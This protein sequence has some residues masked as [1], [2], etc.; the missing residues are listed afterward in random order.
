[1]DLL[2]AVFEP[3]PAL[4]WGLISRGIGAVFAISFVSLALQVVPVAGSTGVIPV[5]STLA[6]IRRDFPTWKRFFYF[7]TLLWIDASDFTLRLVAWL[8]A[9]A[10]LSIIVGGPHVPYAFAACFV[11]YLSLDRPMY[12]V[13]PWDSMLFEAGFWGMLLPATLAL[14]ALEASAPPLP[15]VAWVYRLLAFRVIFGF[16]KVKFAGATAHDSG[17]LK[18]FM[19]AQPLPT[20]VGWLAQKM[21]VG[22]FKLALFQM[23]L[24]EIV[25]PFAVFFPGPASTL[26]AIAMIGLMVAIQ[27]TGN[28]G[29]FNLI[30]IVVS[31]SWLDNATALRF[32][33]TDFVSPEGPV[34]LHR[35]VVFH[36]LLALAA[37]PFNTFFG[38]TW[39]NW[40][41]FLRL[42]RFLQ[43]PIAVVR[44]LTPFRVAHAY[45][46]FPPHS[47][48]AAK[49]TPVTEVTWDGAAWHPLV[50]RHW[51][52]LETS[53]PTFCAPHHARFD[54]AVVYE[55]VGVNE[56]TVYRNA[57]GRW[58]PYGH[59]GVPATRA[60]LKK[61]LDG[62]LSDLFY[63]PSLERKMGGPPSAVRVR[64][65]LI[66][67][68]PL[69]EMRATGRYWKKTLA[70]PHVPPIRRGEGFWDVPHAPPELWHFEDLV[71]L[72]RSRLGS[73]MKRVARGE[74]PH[75]LVALDGDGIT[76]EDVERF[77]TEIVPTFSARHRESWL[78]V[79]DTVQELRERHGLAT[80]HRFE[81]IAGRYGALLLAKLEPLF[82]DKGIA[83]LFGKTHATLDV[84]SYFHLRLLTLHIV[85]EGREAYGRALCDPLTAQAHL[86]RCTISSGYVFHALFRYEWLVYQSWKLRLTQM[87]LEHDGRPEPTA[88][89]RKN[90]A[91]G[92]AFARR[93]F[94]VIDLVNYL[95]TQFLD[96]AAAL[97]VPENPPHFRITESREVVR[98]S[99]DG[100]P[101][102][103]VT[104]PELNV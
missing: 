8:G 74:D 2:R 65:Y 99:P 101:G 35:L 69:T 54:Q 28:F 42:P 64:L 66:E 4:I 20:P 30:M 102:Y 19:V 88:T 98:V 31:L 83:P 12:L 6:A 51:P 96:D 58:D 87:C 25:L 60:M 48:P 80:L 49:L 73:L 27:L 24:V 56:N 61:L 15:A 55:A 85:G 32:S 78:G 71:W 46:V 104:P 13:Y 44:A 43:F 40:T 52:T 9:L 103:P 45:G 21:P 84:P 86:A 82:L 3:P 14:P 70:G 18:S 75:A 81:R 34:N 50:H 41:V 57:L 38:F 68:T 93:A 22:L 7:P 76:R 94:G 63:D 1:M 53:K 79:R 36:T 89:E 33:F 91:R 67:P 26:A 90:K 23:F 92:E 37:F 72:R 17:Y 62:T 95:K 59:G 100:P 97:D 39:M 11:L 5:T 16:G 10:S 47:A 77:W 29:F